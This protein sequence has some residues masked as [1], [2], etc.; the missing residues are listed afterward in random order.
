MFENSVIDRTCR[1]RYSI[2]NYIKYKATDTAS[3]LHLLAEIDAHVEVGK[4]GCA[5]FSSALRPAIIVQT[6]RF[7]APQLDCEVIPTHQCLQYKRNVDQCI[8]D[9]GQR[10]M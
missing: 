10:F 1:K 5:I 8:R 3:I 4:I 7:T 2:R 9:T 6:M